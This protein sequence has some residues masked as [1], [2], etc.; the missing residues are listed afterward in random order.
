M[1]AGIELIELALK[2]RRSLE[3]VLAELVIRHNRSPSPELAR[4]IQGI[5]AEIIQRRTGPPSDERGQKEGQA[6]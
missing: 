4:M 6:G 2:E 1:S 3:A 5:E